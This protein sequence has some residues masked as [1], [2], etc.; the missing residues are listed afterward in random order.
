VTAAQRV[1]A[2]TSLKA[3][4][5]GAFTLLPRQRILI[6]EMVRREL[7][8]QHAGSLL[9][10]LWSIGQPLFLVAVYVFIFSVVFQAKIGGT[11]ELPLDYTTY[12]LSGMLG[13]LSFQQALGKAS[14][15]I[16]GNA[17]V[18][19]QVVFR[20]EVLPVVA[21]AT[22]MLPLIVGGA[23]MVVYVL[24]VHGL[25]PWT[26]LLLPVLMGL[27]LLGMIGLAF[28]LGGLG[29]FVRDLKEVVNLY[30]QVGVLLMPVLY[31]PDWVPPAF[32]PVVYANPLSYMTWC[33]QDV[34]YFGRFE[35][36]IAWIVFPLASLSAFVC[37]YHLFA[38]LKPYFGNV[39]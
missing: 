18:V 22:A 5:A 29:P 2:D 11:R 6:T 39:L 27:Q 7:L 38:R 9:G 3:S 14:T 19:K 13:W 32:R 25:P 20:T 37:G 17:R 35:H 24:A 21:A 8:E 34:L 28:V 23:C 26:Y 15:A 4:V 30:S 36:P 12:L 31:L 33:Y 16:V 1:S 10:P